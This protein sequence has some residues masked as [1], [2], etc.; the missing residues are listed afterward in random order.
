MCPGQ[1][2][3]T[4][5]PLFIGS[6]LKKRGHVSHCSE[7]QPNDSTAPSGIDQ[8]INAARLKP[9]FHENMVGLRLLLSCPSASK[10]PLI[11]RN[12]LSS[13]IGVILY[14]HLG[15]HFLRICWWVWEVILVREH[16][17]LACLSL[18]LLE[19]T[20]N[21]AFDWLALFIQRFWGSHANQTRCWRHICLP[22]SKN[23]RVAVAK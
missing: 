13:I 3:S 1:G 2:A 10:P 21:S 5:I 16:L 20:E 22:S 9:R 7:P 4:G 12:E 8:L 11:A 17:P 15:F 23:H 18:L 19:P 6:I 14:E